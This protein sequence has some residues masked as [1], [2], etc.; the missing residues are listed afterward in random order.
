MNDARRLS[1]AVVA[2]VLRLGQCSI[3]QVVAEVG[4]L[5]P[6]A[7]ARRKNSNSRCRSLAAGRARLVSDVLRRAKDMGKIVRVERGIYAPPPPKLYKPA[8]AG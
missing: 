2:A 1:E 5:I 8:T 4:R 3:R 6:A 7:R